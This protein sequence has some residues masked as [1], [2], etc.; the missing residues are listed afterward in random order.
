MAA[1]GKHLQLSAFALTEPG[2]GP[3]PA[4]MSTTAA[5]TEDGS[6]YLLNGRKLWTTNG[7]VADVLVVMAKVPQERGSQGRHH[8]VHRPERHRR[9]DR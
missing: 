4:K 8:R 6:G 9:R 1:E 2:V 5:P 3:I 7:T